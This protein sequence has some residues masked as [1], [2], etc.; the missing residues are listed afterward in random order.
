VEITFV[1][2]G[3]P[4]WEPDDRAVDEPVLTAHGR[5]QAE[6]AADALAREH[7]SGARAFDAIYVSPLVRAQET[8]APIARALGL[9]AKP[10]S[11]L[12]ELTLPVLAG[13]TP[14]QVQAFFRSGRLR[15]PE[16]WWDGYEGGESFRHF[17]ERVTSGVDALLTGAHAVGI[18]E[19]AGHRLWRVEDWNARLVVVAHEGTNAVAISHLLGIDPSPWAP[20]RFTS[21]WTGMTRLHTSML[22]A[23]AVFSLEFFNRT[24]HLA[25]L[26]APSDGRAPRSVR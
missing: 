19:D 22:G 4:D 6:R 24:D 5:A 3:Q 12:R 25:N 13:S 7:G 9:E 16:R 10:L 1:R 23:G 18:H 21:A 2:H 14:A 15:E 20:L 17:Y 8:A 11:W 26:P